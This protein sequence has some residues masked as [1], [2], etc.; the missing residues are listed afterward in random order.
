MPAGY[1]A[2]THACGVARPPARLP[3]DYNFDSP[4]AFDKEAILKCLTELRVG[5]AGWEG[6]VWKPV[7]RVGGGP[8]CPGG[9]A[10][11]LLHSSDP[12]EQTQAAPTTHS[13]RCLPSRHSRVPLSSLQEMRIVEVPVYDFTTHQRSTE[14]RR[15]RCLPAC[16]AC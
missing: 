16:R 5:G 6:W 7:G 1:S 2:I 4:S 3:A 14:T 10:A 12:S 9:W 15:V 13:C 8:S 11:S